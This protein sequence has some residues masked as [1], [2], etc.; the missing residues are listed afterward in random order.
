MV[1]S[2]LMVST[3]MGYG[4]VLAYL[5]TLF[6]ERF[7]FPTSSFEITSFNICFVLLGLIGGLF[8]DIDRWEQLGL[9]HRKTLHYPAGYG[10][11][12]IIL[13]VLNY[14]YNFSIWAIGFSC[15]LSGAWLHSFMDIFDGF[16]AEDINKGVYEHITKRWIKALNLVP[17]ASLWEWSLQSLSGV[18]A[19]A[20]SPQLHELSSYSGWIVAAIS[21]FIIWLFSTIYEFRRTVP[22]RLEMEKRALKKRGLEPKRR[23]SLNLSG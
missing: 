14:F 1:V 5:L 10:L 11:L 22:K 4:F 3:H 19:I 18:F 13:I 9:S 20:I 2:H 21:F 7:L 8:P 6:W 23:C 16:W 12:A 15:F 17:F